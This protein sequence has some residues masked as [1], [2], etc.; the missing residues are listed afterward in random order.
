MGHS[1]LTFFRSLEMDKTKGHLC[2]GEIKMKMIE[3]LTFITIYDLVYSVLLFTRSYCRPV[4][5][6][7]ILSTAKKKR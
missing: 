7:S 6:N 5:H 2:S 4:F 3:K 1:S